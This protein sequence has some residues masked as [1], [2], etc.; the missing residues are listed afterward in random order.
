M[1]G[2]VSDGCP[3]RDTDSVV[4]SKLA[5]SSMLQIRASTLVLTWASRLLLAVIALLACAV[6]TRRA[7]HLDP[8]LSLREE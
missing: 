2:A 8:M 4:L 7:A 3:Y 6:P 1:R 5:A